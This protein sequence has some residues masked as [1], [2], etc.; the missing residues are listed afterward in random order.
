MLCM[1]PDVS[2]SAV[3]CVI[4]VLARSGRSEVYCVF[5]IDSMS[6]ADKRLSV[7]QQHL[8]QGPSSIFESVAWNPTSA[9]PSVWSHVPQVWIVCLAV[10]VNLATPTAAADGLATDRTTCNHRHRPMLFLAS[11]KPSNQTTTLRS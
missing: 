10:V 11:L 1:Q 6:A 4:L 5:N 7:L 9:E 2:L 8:S 3:Q